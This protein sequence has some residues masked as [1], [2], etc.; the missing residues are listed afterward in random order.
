[1]TDSRRRDAGVY[2]IGHEPAAL[3]V[4]KVRTAEVWA[5]FLL[6]RLHSGMRLLD[7]GCG[8]GTI[9]AGLARAVAPGEVIGF[10]RQG[11]QLEDARAHARELGVTNVRFET[12]DA[13]SMPFPDAGFDAIFAHALL[14]HVADP[15]VVLR[16]MRRVLR[17]GGVLGIADPVLDGWIV[18]GPDR[19]LLTRTFDLLQRATTPHGGDWNRGRYLVELAHTAGFERLQ[20]LPGYRHAQGDDINE[21]ARVMAGMISQTSL[22]DMIV[23]QSLATRAE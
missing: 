7:C 15:V 2:T 12:G 1:M 8:P 23:D 21:G 6:P 16:E 20:C 19:A 18:S 4:M 11:A 13:L 5:D 10:D 17:P 9:T 14:M 3:A 22:A